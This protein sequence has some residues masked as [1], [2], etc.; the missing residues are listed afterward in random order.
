MSQSN[1][2]MLE[3]TWND[4]EIHCKNIASK[5]RD[6]DIKYDCIIAVG[7]GG[8]VPA[9]IISEMLGVKDIYIY[10]I[11]SYSGINKVDK[12]VT[13]P[14][15]YDLLK[16]KKVLII[17]DVYTTGN[18]MEHVANDIFTNVEEVFIT[19]VTLFENTQQLIIE[20]QPDF[21]S[22][23]YNSELDWI[24]FPWEKVVEL[25]DNSEYEV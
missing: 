2:N 25:M 6:T 8:M 11:S 21:Y 16:D 7:R 24:V 18:T 23:T 19:T 4:I 14:F 3:L 10:N 12:T 5:L 20:R 15:N 1:I 17:D 13:K 9:R 22:G